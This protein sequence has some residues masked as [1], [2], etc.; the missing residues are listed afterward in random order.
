MFIDQQIAQWMS[1]LSHR[2]LWFGESRLSTIYM[3]ANISVL[4]NCLDADRHNFTRTRTI[5]VCIQTYLLTLA[6][7]INSDTGAVFSITNSVRL[8]LT[9]R[10]YYLNPC[11]IA[12]CWSFAQYKKTLNIVLKSELVSISNQYPVWLTCVMF[13]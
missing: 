8:V 12:L 10:E 13:N 7:L 11:S 2:S 1:I 9:L 3:D 6:D 4:Y 5:C